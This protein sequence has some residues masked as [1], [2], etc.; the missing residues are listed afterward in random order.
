MRRR[1]EQVGSARSAMRE[2][3]SVVTGDGAILEVTWRGC[4][5]EAVACQLFETRSK[6]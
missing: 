2:C 4:R 5:L 3:T 6:A 1:F